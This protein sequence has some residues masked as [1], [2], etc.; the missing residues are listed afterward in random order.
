MPV[1]NYH[2]EQVEILELTQKSIQK[3]IKDLARDK[4]FGSPT[5]YDIKVTKTGEGKETRYSTMGKPPKKLDEAIAQL[6]LD[7]PINLEALFDNKNPFE[8][9]SEFKTNGRSKPTV[10]Q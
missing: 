8:V 5:E 2:T 6:Y 9:E 1:F 4:D 7:T 10:S 3:A